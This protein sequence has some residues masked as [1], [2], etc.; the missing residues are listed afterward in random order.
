M[1]KPIPFSCFVLSFLIVLF[2]A[3]GMSQE[4]KARLQ[5]YPVPGV[6]VSSTSLSRQGQLNLPIE[7]RANPGTIFPQGDLGSVFLVTTTNDTGDGSLR[8]A[9]VDANTNPGL[10]LIS[11]DIVPPGPKTILPLSKLPNI[12]DPVTIDGT[13]QPGFVAKPIIEINCSSVGPFQAFDVFAPGTTIRGLVINRLTG[14]TGIVLHSGSNGS[15]VEG[16]FFGTDLTGTIRIG[17]AYNGVISES[18]N[19]RIGGTAS[20]ARNV[21]AGQGNPPIALIA[22]GNGNV[23]QGNFFGTDVTGTVRLGN[24]EDGILI[25]FG[26]SNDTIGGTTAAARNVISASDNFSGI[27]VIG[28]GEVGTQGIRIQGNYIGTD[29]TGNLTFGNARHGIYVR[30]SPRNVIGGTVPGARNIISANTLPGILIDSSGSTSNIIQGNYIG[31]RP[32]GTFALPNS[33]GIVLNEAPGNLIGGTPPGAR[34]LITGNSGVGIEI[35]GAGATGN[36][37]QG[38]Y[39]GTDPS[40]QPGARNLGHGILVNA[41]QDTIGGLAESDGNLIAYNGGAGVFIADGTQNLLWN[42][43]MRLN[44]GLGIDL[45]PQGVTVNDSLDPDKGPNALQN[46][47]LL[48]SAVVTSG[49][50]TIHGRLNSWRNAQYTLHFYKNSAAD[51]LHFGEGDSLI[52]STI[53]TTNDTGDVRFSATFPTVVASDQFVTATATNALGNTS[54]FSQALCLNDLDGDGIMDCWETQGWGIDVNSDNVIDLDLHAMGAS[55]NQKDL[56]VEVD[57]M[58]TMSPSD[59]AIQKVTNAFAAAP[60]NINLHVQVDDTSLGLVPWPTSWWTHFHNIKRDSFGTATERSSPNRRHILEAKRLVFR[61][62]IFAYSKDTTTSGGEA[63]DIGCNDFMVTL[64]EWSTSGGTSDQRAGTFMHELGHTLGLRHGGADDVNYKPNYI[65]IMNYTWQT[66]FRW[67]DTWRLDYSTGALPVLNENSLSEQ[68]GL[69]TPAGYSTI[70]NVPFSG[71]DRVKKYASSR[72]TTS[73]DWDTSGT[74]STTPVAVD[75]NIFRSDLDPSP[76]E[77]FTSQADWPILL[78]NFR[79]TRGFIDGPPARPGPE[80]PEM[81]Y[82]DFL[83]LDSLPPPKPKHFIMDG[84]LD[85]EAVRITSGNGIALYAA[86]LDGELYVAT[87]SAQS[88]NADMFI[89]VT[90]DIENPGIPAPW[91][92]S[93]QVAAWDAFLANESSDNSAGWYNANSALKQNNTTGFPGPNILEGVIDLGLVVGFE[94]YRAVLAVGKYQT[95]D[96]GLLLAQAPAGDEDGDI[97][98]NGELNSYLPGTP[99]YW[100]QTAG[101]VSPNVF[102]LFATGPDEIYAGAIRG[103]FKTTNGGDSWT[104]MTAGLPQVRTLDFERTSNGYVYAASDSGVF[105]S[106]NSGATWQQCVNGLTDH[107]AKAL[108]VSPQ[109]TLFVGTYSAGAFRS[110]DGGANWTLIT[111]GLPTSAVL[112]FAVDSSGYLL[113]GLASE[114]L[115]RSTDDGISWSPAGL[116]V[117]NVRSISVDRFGRIYYVKLSPSVVYRSADGGASWANILQTSMIPQ[118]MGMDAEGRIYAATAEGVLLSSDDGATWDDISQGIPVTATWSLVITSN[119]NVY[120]GTHWDGVCRRLSPAITSVHDPV[121]GLPAE[122]ALYQNYPNPFNPSTTIRFN[123]PSKEHVEL[124]V[125]DILGREVATLVREMLAPGAYTKQWNAIGMASG[126]YFYRLQVGNFVETRKLIL[127]R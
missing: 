126:V 96:G 4:W 1:R 3:H 29:A 107:E 24:N 46:F 97:E 50:I 66:P 6:N 70:I 94:P 115:Y 80:I 12:V 57:A 47:P 121:I 41:S 101:P 31:T 52:G 45:A 23:V 105:F 109:G 21:F 18:S 110:T 43:R 112:A 103:G 60:P 13:T 93:G 73:V 81:T 59:S 7:L 89:F 102:S 54:E 37:V 11:F 34:N 82:R 71:P 67:A 35:S 5:N 116:L 56:F 36:K 16:N 27:A 9:I 75:V 87:N 10:D 91:L 20:G 63:E 85:P 114:G 61:Y 53:V 77:T 104:H 106:T 69:G 79:H 15:V 99:R 88:Q 22:G 125:F 76:G 100:Y 8:K 111:N 65:S 123:V 64:G 98:A 42:N 2:S 38:N 124:R 51:A 28:T 39:I 122:A 30:H 113:A 92:K 127:L 86:Y 17:N 40:G 32:N 58:T 48:D 90:A 26:A 120:V 108:V 14:G 83:D 117:P 119:N 33:K 118:E 74:I 78:Y 55:P 62:C 49:G 19:N 25:I 72:P 44:T 95:N 84:Q 68:T